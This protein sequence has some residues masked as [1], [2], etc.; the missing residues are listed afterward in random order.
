[1]KRLHLVEF[2]DEI[3][4]LPQAWDQA[5]GVQNHTPFCIGYTVQIFLLGFRQ[6]GPPLTHGI[7]ITSPLQ[8]L[9]G[10]E[11][12]TVAQRG[13]NVELISQLHAQSRRDI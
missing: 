6:I 11:D 5:Q 13:L 10:K 9:K 8:L 2:P 3:V 4:N 1:M 12:L 7:D